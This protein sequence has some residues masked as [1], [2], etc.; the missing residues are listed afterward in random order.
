MNGTGGIRPG[1]LQEES[2]TM[3]HRTSVYLALVPGVIALSTSAIFVKLANAP[4]S[5]TAFYRLFFTA[6]ALAPFL[7]FNR[8]KRAELGALRPKQ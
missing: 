6:L 1:R 3:K 7:L 4:S 2:H 8:N 5:V